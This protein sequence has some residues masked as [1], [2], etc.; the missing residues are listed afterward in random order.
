MAHS[1]LSTALRAACG[2]YIER[3][4]GGAIEPC[5]LYASPIPTAPLRNAAECLHFQSTA[6]LASSGERIRLIGYDVCGCT[7]AE[8]VVVLDGSAYAGPRDKAAS[9][10][11]GSASKVIFV[12]GAG[13]A[14][15]EMS[16]RC[17]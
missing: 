11:S 3:A 5:T 9:A 2:V 10:P 4:I 7:R 14:V 17:P 15:C 12:S 13:P 1:V 16:L 8:R 6:S